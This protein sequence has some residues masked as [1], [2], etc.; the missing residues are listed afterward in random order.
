[1]KPTPR[2][3]VAAVV[4]GAATLLSACTALEEEADELGVDTR[5]SPVDIDPDAPALDDDFGA[6]NFIRSESNGQMSM[7]ATVRVATGGDWMG[8]RDHKAQY[9]ALD[10]GIYEVHAR[11]ASGCSGVGS[12]AAEG[13]GVIGQIHVRNNRADI[14]SD[15]S[16]VDS[17]SLTT[18]ALVDGEGILQSCAK[19]VKWSDPKQSNDS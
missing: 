10:D 15:P 13:L 2:R 12:E 6:F 8:L 4:A 9:S 3:R 16:E 19:S 14:W 5:I 17:D 18:V 1:M 7:L 11:G